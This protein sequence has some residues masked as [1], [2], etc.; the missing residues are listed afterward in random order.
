MSIGSDPVHFP[1][2]IRDMFLTQSCLKRKAR[3][4][5]ALESLKW[6]SSLLLGISGAI[7]IPYGW[8]FVAGYASY[9][10]YV[11]GV[12]YIAIGGMFAL[13][14]RPKIIQPLALGFTLFLLSAWVTGGYR[15]LVAYADKAVEVLLVVNLFLLIQRTWPSSVIRDA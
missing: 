5:Q 15:D 12:V 3:G 4:T 13:N 10:W 14:F 8:F 6:T 2:P 11:M 7:D 1:V 9:I